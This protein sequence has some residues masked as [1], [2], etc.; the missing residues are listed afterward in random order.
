MASSLSKRCLHT[1]RQNVI[2]MFY[3]AVDHVCLDRK[4]AP[5]SE[6][7]D[8]AV[9]FL[10]LIIDRFARG[11]HYNLKLCVWETS[12]SIYSKNIVLFIFV[13]VSLS[14]CLHSALVSISQSINQSIN[15][16]FFLKFKVLTPFQQIQILF[17]SQSTN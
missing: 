11:C 1:F 16:S 3:F 14:N 5:E 8:I 9:H 4:S 12:L 13:S 6:M 7:S 10:L 17:N 15:R 2:Y